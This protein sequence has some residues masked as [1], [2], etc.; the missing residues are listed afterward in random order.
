MLDYVLNYEGDNVV[1]LEGNHESRLRKYLGSKYLESIGKQQVA[2]LLLWGLSNDFYTR[3]AIEFSDLT[4][5][6]GMNY[7]RKMNEKLSL[8]HV[9]SVP[10][11]GIE[12]IC[13]HSGFRYLDQLTPKFIGNVVYGSRNMDKIDRTFSEK[14]GKEKNK[15]SIHAHCKYP[16]EW[17]VNKYSH[18]MNIDP[19]SED[20][21]VIMTQTEQSWKVCRIINETL[22]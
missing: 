8:Y 19:L 22:E 1:W 14:V 18:V 11:Q 7:I 12:Y 3:T 5:E 6:E 2:E 9:I 10:S 15:W 21:I 20:E 13:T 16:E 4:P 17:K